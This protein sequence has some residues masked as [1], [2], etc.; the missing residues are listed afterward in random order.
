MATIFHQPAEQ[1][2]G[3]DPPLIQLRGVEKV[4]RTGKLE[5]NT[6]G[7]LR[8]RVTSLYGAAPTIDSVEIA[9]VVDNSGT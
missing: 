5:F 6:R 3:T 1:R 9:Q 7:Q 4:Y 2:S 8:E